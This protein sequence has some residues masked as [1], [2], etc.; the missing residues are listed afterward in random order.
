MNT[1]NNTQIIKHC[2]NT[3]GF[4]L[5]Y[6]A[7]VQTNMYYI[8]QR[9]ATEPG[10]ENTYINDSVG[11]VNP[12]DVTYT[13]EE[14]KTARLFT[15]EGTYTEWNGRE[16]VSGLPWKPE[17]SVVRMD[18]E[19]F[20]LRSS[21]RE[22][23]VFIPSADSGQPEQHLEIRFWSSYGY[24]TRYF[25]INH[26]ACTSHGTAGGVYN[27]E[28]EEVERLPGAT[29]IIKFF[30]EGTLVNTFFTRAFK[31][32]SHVFTPE[33]IEPRPS[34]T[35]TTETQTFTKLP[36]VEEIEVLVNPERDYQNQVW[37]VKLDE[38]G[39]ET[40]REVIFEFES[41]PGRQAPTYEITCAQ[42][43]Q[44]QDDEYQLDCGTH[45]C[46]YKA[47]GIATARIER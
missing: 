27:F 2:R 3:N 4:K 38:Q 34:Y 20:E 28:I 15:V 39:Q 40:H 29:W 21:Q 36:G 5:R 30:R 46:C 47:D 45:Y 17:R 19:S 25:Q 24:W 22:P 35:R 14:D 44:C 8:V 10:Q 41:R 12:G 13:V 6:Q 37:R 16:C 11:E 32:D 1:Q 31:G 7:W 33:I 18:L 9:F 26:G 42:I 43:E 23:L